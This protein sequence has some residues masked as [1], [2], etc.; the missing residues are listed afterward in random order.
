MWDL[1]PS[2]VPDVI[3]KCMSRPDVSID[4]TVALTLSF[5]Y[6]GSLRRAGPSIH[7]FQAVARG[8]V[9][10]KSV[11]FGQPPSHD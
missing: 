5:H 2:D 10:E 3:S 1:H 9:S 8:N 6:A 4:R 7:R 11:S